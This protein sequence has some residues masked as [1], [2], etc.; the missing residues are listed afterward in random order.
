MI[1]KHM[2]TASNS[3]A[4][5]G[6]EFASAIVDSTSVSRRYA[7]CF[8][9]IDASTSEATT[10][11]SG[12]RCFN[13]P[14]GSPGPLATSSSA[15]FVGGRLFT[16]RSTSF[17]IVAHAGAFRM[18]FRMYRSEISPP[19]DIVT[20]VR[21]PLVLS[22]VGRSFLLSGTSSLAKEARR[23][24]FER[25]TPP[26]LVPRRFLLLSDRPKGERAGWAGTRPFHSRQ[27]L[28]P[29]RPPPCRHGTTDD[30]RRGERRAARPA[31]QHDLLRGVFISVVNFIYL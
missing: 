31:P 20:S 19:N 30:R 4:S 23:S 22:F 27:F 28:S 9:I 17:T 7:F 25:T 6:S 13:P 26:P 2:V 24:T 12:N 5:K 10:R 18:K 21:D 15:N 16:R 1:P 8:S 14:A 3:S 11:A 29:T